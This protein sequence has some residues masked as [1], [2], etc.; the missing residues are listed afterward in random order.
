LVNVTMA[1][2][3]AMEETS[4]KSTVNYNSFYFCLKCVCIYIQGT[5]CSVSIL[6]GV[7]L[8]HCNTRCSRLEHDSSLYLLDRRPSPVSFLTNIYFSCE[9]FSS[10]LKLV[11]QVGNS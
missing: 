5:I 2:L 4:Q 10:R 7:E 3:N 11:L 6:L 1:F 9:N 8:H